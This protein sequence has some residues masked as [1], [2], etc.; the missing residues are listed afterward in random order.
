[1]KSSSPACQLLQRYYPVSLPKGVVAPPLDDWLATQVEGVVSADQ[2]ILQGYR[3]RGITA[4]SPLADDTMIVPSG[5]VLF[6][7]KTQQLGIWWLIWLCEQLPP[8]TPLDIVG[9][10]SGGIKRLP[11]VLEG[12]GLAC[13]KRDNARRC[14]L[15]G[16]QTQRLERSSA[17]VWQTFT[18][19]GLQLHSH[20]GVF[21]HGK[22][23]EGTALLL[24]T[25]E[26][27]LSQN[28]LP[29]TLPKCIDIGCGDGVISAWLAQR[30]QQVTAVDI[31]EFALDA[32]RRTL[33]A[34]QLDA[35][36]LA[37]DVYSA[38]DNEQFDL[39]I[40]NPPFHQERDIHY[41]AAGKLIR[42]APAHLA[43][44]GQLILV[45]NAFLPY[46]DLLADT[47]ERFDV[48]ANNRRFKVYRA[49]ER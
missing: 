34:N 42:E 17:A 19:R 14:S 15:F 23:D 11:K 3:Q 33:A 49:G 12:L 43:R 24:D 22:L 32:C 18:L 44:G 35:R 20:P 47:F 8:G 31:N 41:G 39:I 4:S 26:T 21:G 9:E 10:H 5:W 27:Q 40:S 6:W 25:L 45:A 37:S 46:A 2:H 30:S 13:N 28:K 1:M 38:V 29:E 48:L 16:T 7:P 36:V